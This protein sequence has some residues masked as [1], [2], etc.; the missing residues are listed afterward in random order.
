MTATLEAGPVQAEAPEETALYRVYGEAD[1]LLYIGVSNDFGRRWREHAK[2][3]PWW[4]E[5]RRMTVDEWFGSRPEAEAA[6]T[7][8]IKAEKP[9]YNK[10]HLVPVEY[11]RKP[12]AVK[13]PASSPV[14]PARAAA[15]AEPAPPSRRDD[16]SCKV[17]YPYSL[18]SYVLPG[19]SMDGIDLSTPDGRLQAAEAFSAYE[20]EALGVR[21]FLEKRAAE[22]LAMERDLALRWA[23]PALR[24]LRRNYAALI[25]DGS[26]VAMGADILPVAAILRE[27]ERLS[28]QLGDAMGVVADAVEAIDSFHEDAA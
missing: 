20:K 12:R 5:R 24:K 6:E 11:K 25:G 9:K 23:V 18:L 10:R 8:A 22:A 1:L 26:S 17:P 13:P 7:A 16:R 15:V 19:H 4:N 21:S 27:N 28:R 2:K 3:Q 14:I